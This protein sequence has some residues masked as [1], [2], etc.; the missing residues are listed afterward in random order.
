MHLLPDSFLP[1]STR[2]FR[3]HSTHQHIYS[4]LAAIKNFILKRPLTSARVLLN[5]YLTLFSGRMC[6]RLAKK[7]T[8]T[9]TKIA[10]TTVLRS[11]LLFVTT[12]M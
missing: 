4:L 11:S 5:L 8:R 6:R 3:R 7:S 1:V 10:A 12:V 2:H 9:R